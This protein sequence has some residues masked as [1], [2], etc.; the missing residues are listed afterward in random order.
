VH[1]VIEVQETEA[2][3]VLNAGGGLG[4][5]SSTHPLPFHDSAS[6]IVVAPLS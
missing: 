5:G 3:D 2:N 1:D 4:T 6:A